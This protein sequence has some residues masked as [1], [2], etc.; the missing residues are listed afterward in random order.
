MTKRTHVVGLHLNAWELRALQTLAD[1]D[2]CT[3]QTFESE[4][5][6]GKTSDDP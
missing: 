5:A 4:C 3:P 2:G 1:R 6:L